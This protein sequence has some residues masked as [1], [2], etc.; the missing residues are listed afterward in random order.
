MAPHSCTTFHSQIKASAV[1]NSRNVYNTITRCT[2]DTLEAVHHMEPHP[3]AQQGHSWVVHHVRS[4]I[5]YAATSSM[6]PHH[7]CRHITYT[8][9]PRVQPHHGCSH[10]PRMQQSASQ[11]RDVYLAAT[12][13]T[14]SRKP[15][16]SAFHR[17]PHGT[18]RIVQAQHIPDHTN[19]RS[20]STAT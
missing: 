2:Y 18:D 20:D 3:L 19:T 16:L 13:R 11:P 5:R 4:H 8:A 12:R 1:M 14:Y 10:I 9:T 7:V 17:R 6:K 15:A